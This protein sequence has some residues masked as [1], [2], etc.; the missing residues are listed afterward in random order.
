MPSTQF[1]YVHHELDLN[2]KHYIKE[3]DDSMPNITKMPISN[4][5]NTIGNHYITLEL[6]TNGFLNNYFNFG[7]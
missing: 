5:L 6:R 4:T 1:L 7:W 3:V 2:F